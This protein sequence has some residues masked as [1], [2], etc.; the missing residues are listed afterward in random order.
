MIWYVDQQKEKKK[1]NSNRRTKGWKMWK[2]L[3]QRAMPALPDI[4]TVRLTKGTFFSLLFFFVFGVH[5]RRILDC[6]A[7]SFVRWLQRLTFLV[8]HMKKAQWTP[9]PLR[10]HGANLQNVL[11]HNNPTGPARK[12]QPLLLSEMLTLPFLLPV[13]GHGYGV[14]DAGQRPR[15]RGLR[16][17]GPCNH[18]NHKRILPPYL[19]GT[20]P[21]ICWLCGRGAGDWCLGH[22]LFIM[23]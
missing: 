6:N 12:D 9:I 23:T 15:R 14:E 1:R 22:F 18:S 5:Y 16:A 2:Q 7:A 4:S 17:A 20:F 10:W 19:E 11:V 3:E 21:F 13:L 8:F